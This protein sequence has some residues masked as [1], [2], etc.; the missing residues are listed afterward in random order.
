MGDVLDETVASV[1]LDLQNAGAANECIQQTHTIAVGAKRSD[2]ETCFDSDDLRTIP[3]ATFTP[4]RLYKLR[5]A[6]CGMVN[7]P[8]LLKS[9]VMATELVLHHADA[10]VRAIFQHAPVW[11]RGVEPGQGPPQGLKLFRV[12]YSREALR[13][14]A[15]TAETEVAIVSSDESNQVAFYRPV[16]P[17]DWHK[18]WA[19]T[20]WTWGNQIGNRGWALEQLED[21][22]DWHGSAPPAEW[23]LRLP[24]GIFLQCPRV[25][26][27]LN[28]GVCRL[29][30][31]PNSETLLRLE[32]GVSALQPMEL[33]DETVVGFEPPTLASLRC[34]VLQKIG[35]L[36]GEPLFVKMSRMDAEGDSEVASSSERVETL[37]T[38]AQSQDKDA[39][40]AQMTTRK[41]A[42]ATSD[43][44]ELK[45]PRDALR[46]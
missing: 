16:P 5:F 14:T 8:N 13:D 27:D 3:V 41:V 21:G 15:P 19:G 1:D 12:L 18:Q 46:L 7:G 40:L 17:F 39:T 44:A 43:K 30:W 45:D 37:P 10:R 2:C 34:D 42:A 22:D 32:A 36:E 4:D 31:L 20:S 11:E 35:D 38:P 29:A 9:G 23:N 33:E 24:G 26:T 6:A 28:V 25:I